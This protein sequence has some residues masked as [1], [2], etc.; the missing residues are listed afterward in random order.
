MPEDGWTE[1]TDPVAADT[2]GVEVEGDA[3][4][5]LMTV[6]EVVAVLVDLTTRVSLLIMALDTPAG[7]FD[8][9][10]LSSSLS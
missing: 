6:V 9:A 3:L 7:G 1:A 2:A 8:E 5:G 4:M 10:E